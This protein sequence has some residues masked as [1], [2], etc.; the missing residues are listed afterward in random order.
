M[1]KEE[2][3]KFDVVNDVFHLYLRIYYKCGEGQSIAVSGSIPGLGDWQ[4]FTELKWTTGDYWVTMEPIL[5]MKH[6][7]RYKYVLFD[8][9]QKKRIQWERG[10]DRIA[11]L[12]ILEPIDR[13][14]GT[15]RV[16][17]RMVGT[18]HLR[19]V[20]IEDVWE[21]FTVEFSVNHPS[22]DL[23]DVMM[24]DGNIHDIDLL[25]MRRVSQPEDWMPVKYGDQIQPWKVEVQMKNNESGDDGKWKPWTN[26]NLIHYNYVLKN[27]PKNVHINEREPERKFI[28]QDPHQYTGQL[29]GHGTNLW[30]NVEEVFVVNGYVNKADGNFEGPF[31]LKTLE[32]RSI[33][34]GSYPSADSDYGV[35][36]Q[37]GCTAVLDI[38]NNYRAVDFNQEQNA[39]R[40]FG[41][42]N[43]KNIKVWDSNE[44][45]YVSTLFQAV[46]ELDNMINKQN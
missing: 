45:Q 24:L 11:D 36:K 1:F 40:K 22:K 33:T 42:S 5:S 30:S 27:K 23:Q 46:V 29:G 8:A 16:V 43:V 9:K 6:Y 14:P 37:A 32:G 4:E 35:I 28:I 3:Q 31:F 18:K 2:S 13:V 7:F 10:V 41:I 26:T 34:I 15:N 19:S 21:E 25:E 38:Q 39:F 12:A 17:Q 20:E 44:T